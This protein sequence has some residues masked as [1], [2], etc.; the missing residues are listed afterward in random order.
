MKKILLLVTSILLSQQLQASFN[1]EKK[2]YKTTIRKLNIDDCHAKPAFLDKNETF[3]KAKMG[4]INPKEKVLFPWTDIKKMFIAS[5]DVIVNES[6]VNG[7]MKEFFITYQLK[8]DNNENIL[9]SI[10][11]KK[12]KKEKKEKYQN[13]ICKISSY[14][15]LKENDKNN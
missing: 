5:S 9:K 10:Q 15:G 14:K 6:F 12:L 11:C 7:K 3:I 13:Y 1:I 4:V 2:P 8:N